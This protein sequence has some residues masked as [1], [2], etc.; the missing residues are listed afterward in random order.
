MFVKTEEPQMLSAVPVCMAHSVSRSADV[1][2][3]RGFLSYFPNQH[4]DAY[5]YSM[6]R[7]NVDCVNGFN[8]E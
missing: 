3:P 7:A 2:E 6:R 4:Q 8:I 5:V 1:L